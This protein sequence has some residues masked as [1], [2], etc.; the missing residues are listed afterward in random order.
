M[1]PLPHLLQG[2]GGGHAKEVR[3]RNPAEELYPPPYRTADTGHFSH[4][5]VSKQMTVLDRGGNR[6]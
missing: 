2:V 5:P 4:S 6:L 1:N 3:V